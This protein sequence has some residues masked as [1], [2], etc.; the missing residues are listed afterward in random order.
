MQEN[1]L[2]T[3]DTTMFKSDMERFTTLDI[4]SEDNQIELLNALNGCDVKLIDIVGQT[5]EI[6]DLYIEK[7][8]VENVDDTTGEV[9]EANKYRCILF[10]TDDKTYVA[11]AYGVYNSLA[12]I[13]A[14][15]GTPSVERP[16]KLEVFQQPTGDK[17][18]KTLKLKI[19][20]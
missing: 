5:I 10:G 1:A 11:G 19:V 20:K 8:V 15:L 17:G 12:Q 6:K 18:R 13:I 14:L 9:K 2:I 3:T 16:F 4:N 7:R